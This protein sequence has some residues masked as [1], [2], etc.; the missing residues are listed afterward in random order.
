[1]GWTKMRQTVPAGTPYADAY[2]YS[3]AVRVANQ[4]HVSGTT[5]QPPDLDG[6]DAYQQAKAALAIIE[7]ALKEVG[8]GLGS[9]VRTVVYVTDIADG[10]L[11]AKAHQEAFGQVYPA[12]TLVEISR[13]TDPRMKV[14]IEVYAVEAN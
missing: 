8:S 6:S 2:G 10:E 5:A 14:E 11:I 4:I 9:V 7:A 3:R 1:M 13:L 12:S